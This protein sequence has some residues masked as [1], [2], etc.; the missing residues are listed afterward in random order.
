MSREVNA[1]ANRTSLEEDVTSVPW[2]PTA[3]DAQVVLNVRAIQLARYTIAATSRA[4]SASV[5]KRASMAGSATS[6]SQAFGASQT[7]EYVSVMTTRTSVISRQELVLSAETLPPVTTAIAARTATTEI[8][9]SESAFRASRVRVQ[10]VLPAGSSMR[11]PA[12]FSRLTTLRT[13]FVIADRDTQG[14]VALSAL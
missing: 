4:D 11:T 8:L 14:S 3:S 1:N 10:V 13:W 5:A 2:E 9:A 12:T 7:A 6:A